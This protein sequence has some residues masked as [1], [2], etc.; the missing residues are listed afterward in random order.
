M[1]RQYHE[2]TASPRS[3]GNGIPSLSHTKGLKAASD[4]NDNYCQGFV[5]R[6]GGGGGA[7]VP[8]FLHLH[9]RIAIQSAEE[10]SSHDV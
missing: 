9:K 6:R 2:I 5:Q 3:P 8:E 10:L 4:D 7:G 1:Q